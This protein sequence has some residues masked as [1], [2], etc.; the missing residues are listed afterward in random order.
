MTTAEV[1]NQIRILW[2][3]AAA[4]HYTNTHQGDQA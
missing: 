2:G 1:A 4:D 3:D